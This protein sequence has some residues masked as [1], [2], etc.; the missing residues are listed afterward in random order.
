MQLSNNEPNSGLYLDLA[1]MYSWR[2]QYVIPLT[3]NI[4]GNLVTTNAHK[5]SNL[6]LQIIKIRINC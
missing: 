6:A 1:G 5:S 2:D 4:L 3:H